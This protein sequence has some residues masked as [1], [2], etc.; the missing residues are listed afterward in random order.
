MK[1]NNKASKELESLLKRYNDQH[2]EQKLDLGLNDLL[3]VVLRLGSDISKN[4]TFKGGWNELVG[5]VRRQLFHH[6]NL[7]QINQNNE[8]TEVSED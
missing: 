7:G 1:P 8:D 2:P 4:P 3:Y 6:L 5:L